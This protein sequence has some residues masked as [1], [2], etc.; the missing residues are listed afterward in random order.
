MKMKICSDIYLEQQ[1]GKWILFGK[2]KSRR[3]QN[4]WK[5][6]DIFCIQISRMLGLR[7]ALKLDLSKDLVFCP[8]W[9]GWGSANRNYFTKNLFPRTMASLHVKHTK[10]PENK[11]CIKYRTSPCFFFNVQ[12]V[13]WPASIPNQSRFRFIGGPHE[14]PARS[15]R[16]FSNVRHAWLCQ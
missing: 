11:I 4:A 12:S 8:N 10:K 13:F 7:G 16:Q 2:Y 9:G 6:Q 15:W 14:K 3:K 5:T 1:K